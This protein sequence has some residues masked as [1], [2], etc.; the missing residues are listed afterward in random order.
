[1]TLEAR[2]HALSD[3]LVLAYGA[4]RSVTTRQS[5]N[6]QELVSDGV[7]AAAI[8]SRS[9]KANAVSSNRLRSATS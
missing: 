5:A 9:L 3:C 8:A 7:K 2:R 1:M 4:S 6:P